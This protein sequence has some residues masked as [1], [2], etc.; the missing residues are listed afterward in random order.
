MSAILPLSVQGLSF[1]ANGRALLDDVS[2]DIE[3]DKC[4]AIMGANGAGKSLTLRLIHGLDRPSAG[5]IHWRGARAD[6]AHL[7]QAMVFQRPILL[8]RTAA[9][10]IDYAL[11]V[12]G[13]PKLRR[14][15]RVTEALELVGLKDLAGRPARVLSGGERQLLG[16]ARASALNPEGWV[17]VEPTA[18]LAP[19]AAKRVE[20]AIAAIHAA[21][22]TIAMATHDVGQARR[23]ADEILFLHEGR[24][25]ERAEAARFF[26]APRSREAR[27]YLN[28]ELL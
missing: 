18:S 21:G 20:Q 17:L 24:L 10:N 13:V 6:E 9:A 5:A 15:E 25:V 23:L 22:T 16:L 14:P 26:A 19:A 7:Y 11:D 3:R 1:R 28:G 12:R 27:A 4:V 2:F 8:R